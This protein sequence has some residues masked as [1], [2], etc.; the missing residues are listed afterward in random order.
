VNC[1]IGELHSELPLKN[2]L[3]L[4]LSPKSRAPRGHGLDRLFHGGAALKL[5]YFIWEVK[6]PHCHTQ[7]RAPPYSLT[8][9]STT[10]PNL[11]SLINF[12]ALSE[13]SRSHLARTER[14]E[15]LL[16]GPPCT[17]F[18]LSPSHTTLTLRDRLKRSGHRRI[19][20]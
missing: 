15:K 5:H 2:F 4:Y 19:T 6:Q 20:I 7:T 11:G 3:I 14:E 10:L 8:V 17:I 18:F 9:P 12:T 16:Q 1:R 13:A